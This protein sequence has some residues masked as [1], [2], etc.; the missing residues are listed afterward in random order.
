MNYSKYNASMAHKL[1]VNRLL[2]L[3]WFN[4]IL[5]FFVQGHSPYFKM[6]LLVGNDAIDS[7]IDLI[8]TL[9]LHID[10]NLIPLVHFHTFMHGV[11]L[12]Q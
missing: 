2:L 9:K 4:F 6:L 3:H 10:L 8:N 11:T 5:S 7:E 12:L 1:H